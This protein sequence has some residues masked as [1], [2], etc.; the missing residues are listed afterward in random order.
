MR[1]KRRGKKLGKNNKIACIHITRNDVRI[2]EGRVS[3]GV[4]L[5]SHSAIVQKAGR[6]FSGDRLA[7]MS[8][9]VS[10]IVTSM[11]MNSITAKELYIVYD[12]NLQVDFFLDEKLIA[13]KENKSFSFGKKKDSNDG[14]AASAKNVGVIE[15]KKE[16]GKFITETEKGQLYTTTK[17]ERDLV[18]FLISEF[19]EHGYKVCSLEAPET[20]LLYLRKMIPFTYDALNKLVLYANDETTGY[21][22]QFTKDAP[23]GGQK[24]VHFDASESN[25]FVGKVCGVIK[26]E[27]R[28]SALHNPHIMLV[29]DA[30]ANPDTYIECCRALQ[31]EGL[32]CMDLYARWKN[33]NLP[34]NC[35]RVIVPDEDIEIERDGRFGICMALF[36]RV[37]EG[38][39]ENLIEGFHL[40]GLNKKTKIGL[41]EV[42]LTV[43]S[44]FL[45]FSVITTGISVYE[46]IVAKSEYERASNAT[47][48]RLALAQQ[49][50][51][52]AKARVDSLS[53]IDRRYNEIFKFVYAQV[54]EDLNIAS[55]DTMD[56]IPST[57]TTG[58]AYGGETT[59]SSQAVSDPSQV[60]QPT[61]GEQASD[62]VDVTGET[63]ATSYT[64]QTI[65]IRGYSRTTDGPV[66]LYK[67]LVNADIG[68]VK[69][70]GVEQVPLPSKETLF[71]FELTVGASE[72]G[73]V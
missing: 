60:T 11:T 9:L 66:E 32:T 13:K 47:E 19:Q 27:I 35:I 57:E 3:S 24:Q 46:N 16:W 56:M 38:K 70:V 2:V 61:D 37:F 45:V 42:G 36:A 33:T 23:S 22:Y 55:I 65:V 72:G 25:E 21:F 52:A 14:D 12:N 48:S 40:M 44:L 71:A 54:D 28:K 69:V 4:I 58:S 64:M 18:D 34:I 15:H 6:F 5:I 29:G 17:I 7:N 63:S 10:A 31:E 62:V 1:T 39:P 53:T 68:E 26:D 41:V 20:A 50:R 43:A 73:G 30:F 51:D 59:D 67:A 8:D 49:Q